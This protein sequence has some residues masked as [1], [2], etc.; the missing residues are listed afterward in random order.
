[1]TERRQ[2]PYTQELARKGIHLSSLTIPLVYVHL[3][4]LTALSVL[5]P[6]TLAALIINVMMYKH[7]ATRSFMMHVIG[8]MLRGHE[9][10]Q[11]RF[12]L[13]GASWVLIAATLIVAL[14]PKIL[15]I[16]SFTVLIIS[17][18]V[19]ALVGRRWGRRRFL[20]KSV[21]GSL[22][23]FVTASLVVA[24]YAGAFSLP[25]T[26]VAAGFI[27]AAVGTVIEAAS[28]RLHVDDNLSIPFSIA[29]TMWGLAAL[30]TQFPPFLESLP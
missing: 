10:D 3:D 12:L 9:R 17:D 21:L 6:M 23:F 16:T 29:L 26:Y 7:A 2:I 11:Q 15:A 20:D 4:R 30:G 19:A 22:M 18:T 5:V 8:G 13:N 28:V 14:T 25:W 24:A 27:G 1:M